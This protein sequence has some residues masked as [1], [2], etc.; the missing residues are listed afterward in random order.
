MRTILVLC[1]ALIIAF[2]FGCSKKKEETPKPQETKEAT[3]QRHPN[4]LVVLVDKVSNE[5]VMEI[6]SP[7]SYEY[8]NKLYYFN[9]AE[10]MEAFKAN[11][12]K[13]LEPPPA[14]Q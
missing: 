2:S 10:N 3:Q 9:S 11:P 14:E 7:Y 12:Q 4:M 5:E 6:P 13:Y 8:E 1:L